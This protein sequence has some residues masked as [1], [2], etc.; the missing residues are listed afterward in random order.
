MFSMLPFSEDI[1]VMRCACATSITWPL[2]QRIFHRRT[3]AETVQNTLCEH[4][5][6][7]T[8]WLYR[9]Q[10]SKTFGF[11]HPPLNRSAFASS[12]LIK[13]IHSHNIN[14]SS[15]IKRFRCFFLLSSCVDWAHRQKRRI[16]R[17]DW[18]RVVH[19]FQTSI[20]RLIFQNNLYK[21]DVEIFSSIKH[22]D[23]AAG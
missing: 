16:F 18:E 6:T 2:F 15:K 10:H 13:R 14:K 21:S 17:S 8:L 11:L 4:F 22:R 19:V 9:Y 12:F 23:Y 5:S 1:S 20:F 3:F 7:E